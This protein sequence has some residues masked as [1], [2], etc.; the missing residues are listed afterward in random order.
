MRSLYLVAATTFLLS[1]CG[2]GSSGGSGGEIPSLD[3]V[4]PIV[5][6]PS[7]ATF[8]AVDA[9]GIPA[10]SDAI[11]AFL[12]D[13]SA[14]DDVDGAVA[15]TNNAP[16]VFSLGDFTVTFSASDAAGNLGTASAVV[17]VKDQT[18]PTLAVPADASFVAIASTGIA[19][20]DAALVDF[21]AQATATDNVDTAITVSN[22][23][24]A[25][26]LIGDTPVEFTAVDA[27]G[28]SVSLSAVV[29]VAGASQAGSAEKGPLL[30]ATVFF[31]YDGDKELDSNEP[32]TLTDFDGKYALVE[33]SDAPA[34]YSVVVLMNDDTIDSIS[35]ESY[36]NS[37][38]QL[39]AVKGSKVI[40]PMTTLY[41]FAVSDL[42]EG[43]ELSAEAFAVALG[44]PDGL[45]I[46]TYSAFAKDDAGAYIDVATASQVEAVAQ[47]LMTALQIISESVVSISKTALQSDT[48]LSQSQ[49]AAVA[50]RS[51]SKV[52]AATVVKNAE[53]G[54]V[55]DKVDFANVDDIAEVNAEVLAG[56]S[57][58]DTNSLGALLQAAAA[59]SGVTVDTAAAQVTGSVVLSLSTKTIATVSQA[60]AD[61]SAASFGQVEASAVSRVKTQAVAEVAAAAEVVVSVVNVQQVANQTVVLT[62]E[63]VDVS[64]LITLDNEEVLNA[65]IASNVQEVEAYLVT[66]VAPVIGSSGSFVAAE[67]QTGVG[68]VVATDTAGDVLAYSLSGADASAL[69]ISN[70]GVLSFVSAPDFETKV[71]YEA[72]VTVVDSNGNTVSQAIT[73]TITDANDSAPIITS[74][75]SFTVNEN[76]SV[77]GTVVATSPSNAALTF[78]LSGTDA[79]ALTISTDG[80]LGFIAAPDFEI[81]S[82]YSV[83]ITVSDGANVTTSAVTVSINNV[84]DM[85]PVFTS[86][87]AFSA[88]ENQT[89]IGTITAADVDS[90]SVTFSVDST[91]LAISSGGVLSFITAADFETKSAYSV[92]VTAT[93]GTNTATQVIA[94]TVTDADEDAPVISSSPAFSAAENQTAIGTVVATDAGSMA[95]SVSGTELVISSAGVLSFASAPDY[96]TKTTYTATVTVT[97]SGSLATSQ[98]ITVAVTNVDDV[99]PVFTSAP[100]FTALDSQANLGVVTATDVDSASITFSISGSELA[101]SSAGVISFVSASDFV[102]D[103]TYTATVTVSDG[104]N[105][106]TQEISIAVFLDFDGDGVANVNDTDDDG[107]GILDLVDDYPLIASSYAVKAPLYLARAYHDCNGNEKF[108]EASEPS[109]MTDTDGSYHIDG[110]CGAVTSFNTVVEMTA[111]TIDFESGESYGGTAVQ[112]KAEYSA[113]GS[114]VN[115]PLTT[116]LKHIEQF[117]GDSDDATKVAIES[118]SPEQLSLAL[119]LTEGVNL[120][121][122]N[123]YAPGV[124]AKLAHDIETLSQ[125]IMLATLVVTKAIEGAGTS[126]SGASVTDDIAHEAILDAMSKILIETIKV[127][128]GKPS[129]FID[130]VS[131]PDASLTGEAKRA[132]QRA[133]KVDLADREHLVELFEFLDEDAATGHLR[134]ALDAI[135]A[136]V[137]VAVLTAITDKTS[138]IISNIAMEFDGHGESDFGSA[139]TYITSRLKHTAADEIYAFAK[140]YRAYYD[141]AQDSSFAGVQPSDFLTL[142]GPTGVAD[143]R[144]LMLVEVEQHAQDKITDTD[145]DGIL[146]VFD[147]DDDNDGVADTDDAFPRDPSKSSDSDPGVDENTTVSGRVIDGYI[148]GAVAFLDLNFD[149]ELSINEPSATSGTDGLFQFALNDQELSCA[150]Y[151]P[152]VVNVPVGAIDEELG[153]VDKAFNLVLPPRFSSLTAASQL[154]VSPITSVVWQAFETELRSSLPD[155]NCATILANAEQRDTLAAVLERSIADVVAHYNISE[156]Q[157]FEDFIATN[158]DGL[159]A[160]AVKIVKGLKKSLEETL[161]IQAQYPNANWAKVNYYFFSSLD[162]DDLYPNAWYRDLELFDGDTITKELIK[163]SDDL[164]DIIRPILY[165]KTTVSTVNGASLRE[166]IGFESRGGDSSAYVCS[167]KEEVSVLVEGIEYQ[168][169]NLGSES[170]VASVDSCKLPDFAEQ[171]SGRYV[172]YRSIF[173]GVDSGAQ[174]VF[175]SQAGDFPAL[176][177]W[178]NLVDNF[179]SLNVDSLASYVDNLPYGFCQSGDAGADSVMRSRSET[180]NGNRVTLSRSENGSYERITTFADGTSETELSTIDSVPGWDDCSAPDYDADGSPNSIDPD[181]DNDGV[182]D[183]IDAFPF[184]FN[185]SIDTDGDGL[186]NNADTDDDNDG[187]EDI[188]DQYPLDSGNF[189]DSDGDGIVDRED[190]FPNDV[191]SFKSLRMDFSASSSLGLGSAL[192]AE[193]NLVAATIPQSLKSD[194][195]LLKLIVDILVPKAWAN[196]VPLSSLTNAITWDDQGSIVLDTILSSETLFVAEAAVTPDGHYLYLLTSNHMQRAISGLDPEV[197]SIYRVMLSDYS[198][199]CLLTTNEG[200]I[201]PK[202][203][204]GT[205]QTDSS[206]RG[207]DFRADGAAVMK[208]FDWTRELPEG[209][210]GGT[211]STIAW[212]MSSKGELIPLPAD[213]GF[214]AVGAL[215]LDDDYFAVAEYPFIYSDD[216]LNRQDVERLAIYH[217]GTLTRVKEVFAPNIW[218]PIVRVNGDLHWLYGGSLNGESMEIQQSIVEGIPYT[219]ITGTRLFG[220]TDYRGVDNTL[221]SSDDSIVLPLSDGVATTYNWSRGS[222]TGTDVSYNTIAFSQDY[223]A[224]IKAYGPSTPIVSIDGQVP[225]GTLTLSGGRGEMTINGHQFFFAPD[226]SVAGDLVIAYQVDVNGSIDS[227]ELTISAATIANWRA[228]TSR[229]SVDSDAR[230]EDAGLKWASPEPDEEGICLYSYSLNTSTCAEFDDYEVLSTDMESFRS[231]RYDDG[232]VYP[233][234]MG[235]AYPGISNVF[236]IDNQLRFFFKDSSDH[237]YYQAQV[238]VNAFFANGVEALSYTPAINGAGEQNIISDATGLTPLSI[239]T[240]D[241][242]S[243]AT[244]DLLSYTIDFGQSL[245]K[246]ATLPRFEIWNGSETVPLAREDL[247]SASR[248]TVTLYA[249][250][251][252]LINGAEHEIR[253]LDPIFLVDSTRR[254]EVLDTLTFTPSGINNFKLLPGAVQLLDYNP[255]TQQ[256]ITSDLTL[257]ASNGVLAA[258]IRN[259][260]IN[261]LNIQNAESGGD[262]KSPTLRF[263]LERLPV[264]EGSVV[265]TIDLIDGIDA[266]RDENERRVFIQVEAD[267]VADGV[268]ATLTVPEQTISAFYVNGSGTKVEVEID[269]FDADLI[270]VNSSGANYP[271]SLDVK[272]LAVLGKIGFIDLSSLLKEG[273]YHVSVATSLPLVD[274]KNAQVNEVNIIFSTFENTN[275][276]LL[277]NSMQLIDYNPSTEQ[278]VTSNVALQMD[279]GVMSA[280]LRTTPLNLENMQNAALG[281]DFKSPTLSFGLAQLPKGQ[282]SFVVEIDLV[283]GVDGVRDD[284]E[285]IVSAQVTADWVSNGIEAIITIPEQTVSAFYINRSG[286]KID[287]EIDNGDADLITINSAGA[288]YPASIDVKWLAALSKI[289]FLDPSSF[290]GEGDYHVSLTTTLPLV[291][292]TNIAVREINVI[293]STA[294]NTNFQLLSNAVQLI[295][296]NPSTQQYLSND[297]SLDVVSGVMSADLRGTPL[298]LENMENTAKGG[299]F[300]S[301]VLSFGL[302]Q[303]PKG[304]GS[305]VLALDLVDGADG[306][307]DVNERRLSAQVTVDWVSDGIDASFSIPAQVVSTTYTTG[308]GALVSVDIENIDSDLISASGNGADYPA[309]LNVKLLSLL[310]KVD[311]VSPSGLLGEGDFHL[312][313]TTD[314]PLTDGNNNTVNQLDV[315]FSVGNVN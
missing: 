315:V 55:A 88:A 297:V 153:V 305:F 66:K 109:A 219:D 8:A 149:G 184:N 172:F 225:S 301:P 235:N 173:N 47:S 43:E 26:F 60:F 216:S 180:V 21:L 112:L 308:E 208:G 121:T 310:S 95:F 177:D 16:D 54:A 100:S 215:W 118:V 13:A 228:D 189:I 68:T 79:A 300:E 296:Y 157:L 249:T 203:L 242:V 90:T 53:V 280:D 279:Y 136:D 155:L 128:E 129:N 62:A 148:S 99:A 248:D 124:D 256:A 10:S 162:G 75:S 58:T 168:L 113:S 298:N 188:Y 195:T 52:I 231:T 41:S 40:T 46:N 239:L 142:D 264:G 171:S 1:A 163:V 263:G 199:D 232:A 261:L 131:P 253:I 207:M 57:G 61:L 304:Q 87:V 182:R 105:V 12:L 205:L 192:S 49:A 170:N 175:S 241:N 213:D 285:R 284:N 77:I 65:T 107:D 81:K 292:A 72:T 27:A 246:Y 50:M 302:S 283:D 141:L 159:K 133:L 145:G 306:D 255:L 2:G 69:T 158:N 230:I 289:D 115:T 19:A 294:D 275:F 24:P 106:A 123:P 140:G 150:A 244:N 214:F 11:A 185:E 293:F 161:T 252:G 144:L 269:N 210:P 119:G 156:A 312:S 277:N 96:E 48:G 108:D 209:V 274:A 238:D 97:D 200:D 160:K 102:A 166:E 138:E 176:N 32:S 198:F 309:S 36:A 245:S 247:W 197:C 125:K 307:R 281:S 126:T 287:V 267:W 20:S 101:I 151:V 211:N 187:V 28:N 67:N 5:I 44:L 85:A 220:L 42:A 164:A 25:T 122:F 93:D 183:S 78:T 3:I 71:L 260:P 196:D 257:T 218:G 313:V 143:A 33:T 288:D 258:D 240:V 6:A 80:V 236:L 291:D 250:S 268:N 295:D 89:S 120:L 137:P 127:Q 221:T 186:G 174:F 82:S 223:I 39:E 14:T 76:Q 204:Q 165:E 64:A 56:L 251:K 63:D 224:Y 17:T 311:F 134:D 278:S 9:S 74:S 91:E 190:V 35:G 229:P 262:F 286:T 154:N 86:A 270:T 169:V 23:A 282:G 31:D 83:I 38:V 84:D 139:D 237:S 227:R 314:L 234:G 111:D 7:S 18:A 217:A 103:A 104:A 114:K 290:L 132:A 146:N 181:D 152:T 191:S 179:A 15:V 51:L 70:M 226:E 22:D 259:T 147:T 193:S 29:T 117:E 273:D 254:Y 202:S 45:N 206:R 212:F 92:T 194:R 222:G 303:L 73:I 272:W 37:G 30:N 271:T 4:S 243:V 98:N 59:V 34:D 135:G 116:L 201:E 178:T 130:N 94:V 299:G 167:Y 276:Q 110:N 233:N 266:V 265:V